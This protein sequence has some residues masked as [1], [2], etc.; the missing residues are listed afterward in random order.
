MNFLKKLKIFCVAIFICSP[1]LFFS[2]EKNDEHSYI[3]K[4]NATALVDGFSFPAVQF[5]LERKFNNSF[6]VQGELGLQLY[7][8]GNSVDTVS[9]DSKGFRAN[10]EGRFYF[11]NY[12]KKNKSRRR[13][14]DGVYAGFQAF[15]RE[16]QFSRNTS[17]YFEESENEELY[18]DNFGVKKKIF[19]ANLA[20]GFQRQFGHF[21]LEPY[22]YIGIMNR[23]IKNFDR[24]YNPHLGH[25]EDNGPHDLFGDTD[26]EESSGYK[27]NFSFGLRLGYRF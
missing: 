5:A 19:G 11:L 24:S 17:Y 6:S 26:M 25:V 1:N 22:M 20:L 2:Q 12:Y 3:L 16:N 21:V 13:I 8:L 10:A 9:I 27:A 15:Y 23:H 14:S 7:D 4:L 18:K